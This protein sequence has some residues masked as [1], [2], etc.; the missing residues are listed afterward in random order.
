MQMLNMLGKMCLLHP[1]MP[2]L[3][4]VLRN[5]GYRKQHFAVQNDTQN[6][7]QLAFL[8]RDSGHCLTAV[9]LLDAVHLFS[10]TCCQKAVAVAFL[11]SKMDFTSQ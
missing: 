6:V 10:A 8:G 4:A 5:V 7:I 1:V 11:A 3:M 9:L 2:S